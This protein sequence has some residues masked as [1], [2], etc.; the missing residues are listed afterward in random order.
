VGAANKLRN[1]RC[2]V[3]R[4]ALIRDGPRRSDDRGAAQVAKLESKFLNH[5]TESRVP[6]GVANLVATGKIFNNFFTIGR[7]QGRFSERLPSLWG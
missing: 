3:S 7:R 6:A 4:N 1:T 5:R 2:T